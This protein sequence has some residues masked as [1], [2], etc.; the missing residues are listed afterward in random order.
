MFSREMGEVGWVGSEERGSVGSVVVG[1][2]V[3]GEA[4]ET[5][6]ER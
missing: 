3:S 1:W 2:V 6:L 4:R 5:T